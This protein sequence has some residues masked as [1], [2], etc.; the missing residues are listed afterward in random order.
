MQTEWCIGRA[1]G[2]RAKSIIEHANAGIGYFILEQGR[3]GNQATCLYAFRRAVDG[4]T[5]ESLTKVIDFAMIRK[6]DA[7]ADSRGGDRAPKR[8]AKAPE[9]M[10][11]VLDRKPNIPHRQAAIDYSQPAGDRD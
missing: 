8:V 11:A 5:P 10:S 9:Q 1:I 4:P 6:L 3:Q 2:D 7:R